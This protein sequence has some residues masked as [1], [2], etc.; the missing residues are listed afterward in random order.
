MIVLA[1][2]V[3]LEPCKNEYLSPYKASKAD[4]MDKFFDHNAVSPLPTTAV[5]TQ[6]LGSACQTWSDRVCKLLKK[7]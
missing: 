3:T 5:V 6:N 4:R 2:I 7:L 1:S